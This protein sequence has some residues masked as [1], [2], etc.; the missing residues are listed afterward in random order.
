M[1]KYLIV[2]IL[3]PTLFQFFVDSNSNSSKMIRSLES[4]RKNLAAIDL[5]IELKNLSKPLEIFEE[6]HETATI[7]PT[8]N[9]VINVDLKIKFKQHS[10]KNRPKSVYKGASQSYNQFQNSTISK[11]NFY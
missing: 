1:Q 11:D 6:K 3:I 10:K 2:L 9:N 5:N 8:T 7:T 4:K